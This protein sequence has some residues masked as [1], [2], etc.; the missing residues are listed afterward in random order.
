MKTLG[1]KSQLAIAIGRVALEHATLVWRGS[2]LDWKQALDAAFKGGTKPETAADAWQRLYN[3]AIPLEPKLQFEFKGRRFRC[4]GGGRCV[5][6][7]GAQPPEIRKLPAE[8]GKGPTLLEQKA[9]VLFDGFV[10]ML[11]GKDG[12]EDGLE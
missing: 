12:L 2:E 7:G 6:T 9:A 11:F 8:L 1:G 5:I 3:E 4:F 10:E